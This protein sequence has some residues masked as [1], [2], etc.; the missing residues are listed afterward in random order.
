MNLK[1]PL[2]YVAGKPTVPKDGRPYL[3]AFESIADAKRFLNCV[4]GPAIGIGFLKSGRIEIW[5]VQAEITQLTD[6]QP[7]EL[8]ISS[9][10]WLDSWV[11]ANSPHGTV[12]CSSIT[13]DTKVDSWHSF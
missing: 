4:F 3:F 2:K 1:S 8:P 7:H 11:K 5:K 6:K 13:L 10:D 12:F 9:V